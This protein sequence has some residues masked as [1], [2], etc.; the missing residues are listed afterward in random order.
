[1]FN[2]TASVWSDIGLIKMQNFGNIIIQVVQVKVTKNL[3]NLECENFNT[4]W[5][6]TKAEC[7][8]S[9]LDLSDWQNCLPWKT[10]LAKLDSYTA[11]CKKS[12]KFPNQY[13][14]RVGLG[15]PTTNPQTMLVEVHQCTTTAISTALTSPSFTLPTISLPGGPQQWANLITGSNPTLII[16]I[17]LMSFRTVIMGFVPFLL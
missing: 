14:F 9:L 16:S 3:T 7:R 6:P 4:C 15:T 13:T 8:N 5:I 1:M 17:A 10:E 11:M 2:L 12:W